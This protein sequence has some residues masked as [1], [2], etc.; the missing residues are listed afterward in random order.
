MDKF[1]KIAIKKQTMLPFIVAMVAALVMVVCVF[2]PYA[3]ATEERAEW[4][5]N[6]PIPW[7]LKKWV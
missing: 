1:K 3:T 4:I 6:I 2:L 5:D 7:N